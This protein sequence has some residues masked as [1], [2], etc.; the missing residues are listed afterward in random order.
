MAVVDVVRVPVGCTVMM[1][2]K[3]GRKKTGANQKKED[4]EWMSPPEDHGRAEAARPG[5]ISTTNSTATSVSRI[6]AS[7]SSSSNVYGGGS[8]EAAR[9]YSDHGV[10]YSAENYGRTLR[11]LTKEDLFKHVKFINDDTELSS[12]ERGTVGQFVTKKLRIQ[13]PGKMIWWLNHK[14]I[15]RRALAVKRNDCNTAMKRVIQ[16]MFVVWCGTDTK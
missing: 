12:L 3:K 5:T 15:V 8:A 9:F 14:E 10:G 1:Y 4:S 16:G 7:E 2:H 13:G 11:T 6:T